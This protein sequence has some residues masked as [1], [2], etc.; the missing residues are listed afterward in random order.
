[1][2][3]FG[4]E[5]KPSFPC[6][7]FAHVKEPYNDVEV[8]FVGLNLIG[9]FSP[10]VSPLA[11]RGL[12]RRLT[13]SASG[14]KRGNQKAGLAQQAPV[15]CSALDGI[16]PAPQTEEEKESSLVFFICI[17]TSIGKTVYVRSFLRLEESHNWALIFC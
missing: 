17:V 12:S 14:D 9:H 15:G 13:W 7:S 16:P 2:S 5:V 1:M 10:I 6:R 11:D 4:G 8:A 3:S